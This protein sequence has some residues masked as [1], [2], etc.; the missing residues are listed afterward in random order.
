MS[1]CPDSSLYSAYIDGEVPS[2]WKEKLEAHIASCPDCRR[3]AERY[4]RLHEMVSAGCAGLT[5][6]NLEASFSRLCI[7]RSQAELSRRPAIRYPAWTHSSVRMPIPALAALFLAAIILPAWVVMK[8]SNRMQGST[9]PQVSSIF[10]ELPAATPGLDQAFR[11][12]VNSNPV[13]STDLPAQSLPVNTIPASLLSDSGRQ[14]FTMI[15]YA[16]HF[17][18]NKDLFSDGDIIIIKL[19]SLT[20]FSSNGDSIYSDG[21]TLQQAAGFYK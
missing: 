10:P 17:D 2:P 8:N 4:R 14:L 5:A 20:Q 9:A 21:D 3:R 18:T 13:Y 1:T 7:R 15:D 6:E 11:T 16:R 19:P 12:Q